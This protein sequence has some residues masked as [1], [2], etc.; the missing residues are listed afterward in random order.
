M[1]TAVDDAEVIAENEQALAAFADGDKTPEALAARP[2][3]ERILQQIRQHGVLY[4]DWG[5]V[6]HVV[7]V[8]VQ[9]AI[10]AYDAVGPSTTPEEVDRSELFNTILARAT[11]PFTLQR[12]I[13][14]LMDPTR[15]YAQSSKFMNAVHKFFQVSSMAETDDP[16]NPRLQSVRRRHVNPS[17]RHL[18]E[19]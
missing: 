13:E 15:Y 14:V 8:K 10:G 7:L 11:P 6:K 4:Y 1:T 2:P 12:L 19:S 17:L 18:V 9:I 3:L 5:L 16:R